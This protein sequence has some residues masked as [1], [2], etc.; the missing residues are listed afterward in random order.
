[1]IEAEMVQS[2]AREKEKNSKRNIRKFFCT[3]KMSPRRKT[4]KK[5]RDVVTGNLYYGLFLN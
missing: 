3:S 4:G 2:R 5:R 1:V